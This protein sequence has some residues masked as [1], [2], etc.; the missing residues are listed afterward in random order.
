MSRLSI[1]SVIPPALAAALAPEKVR[2]PESKSN[3][4]LKDIEYVSGPLRGTETRDREALGI[5]EPDDTHPSTI[6]QAA[7]IPEPQLYD[8]HPN[9]RLLKKADLNHITH[10]NPE[11]LSPVG[12]EEKKAA[13]AIDIDD[14]FYNKKYEV[15]SPDPIPADSPPLGKA[16]S[17]LRRSQMEQVTDPA[18]K[19]TKAHTGF[20]KAIFDGLKDTFHSI[21]HA[22]ASPTP[23]PSSVPRN[24]T[25]DDEYT[26]DDV[27]DLLGDIMR[28]IQLRQEEVRL[29]P[30][31]S[32]KRST[33]KPE[34]DPE[35]NAESK[36]SGPI[37]MIRTKVLVSP[38]VVADAIMQSTRNMFA[39]KPNQY[40]WKTTSKLMTEVQA[41]LSSILEPLED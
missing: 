4:R 34:S 6:P 30:E 33:L 23:S 24:A 3:A 10:A 40:S 19:T 8:T 39:S 17:Q 28:V 9:A 29:V 21:R 18:E 36:K 13:S 25:M 37:L 26:E 11:N 31:S 38:H 15:Q 35:S 5:S 20:L 16:R 27:D 41:K 22:N 2:N 1:L 12:G 32:R 14:A 7:R